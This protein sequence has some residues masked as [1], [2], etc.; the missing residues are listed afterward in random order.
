MVFAHLLTKDLIAPFISFFTLT[1]NLIINAFFENALE[2]S[3][4]EFSNPFSISFWLTNV[5]GRRVAECQVIF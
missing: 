3:F 5:I 1:R 2:Q 4:C